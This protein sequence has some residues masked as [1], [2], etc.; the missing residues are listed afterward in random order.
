MN[1]VIIKSINSDV[2]KRSKGGFMKRFKAQK[3]YLVFMFILTVFMVLPGCGGKGIFGGGEWNKVLQYIEVTPP[4]QSI[5]NG[6]TQQFM[7]TGIYSNDSKSDLTPT[8]TWSSSNTAVATIAANGMVTALT[9]GT[10][11]ITA[12][13]VVAKKSG[14]APLNVTS[15]T[16]SSMVVTPVAQ[17]SAKGTTLQFKATG[18]YSDATTQDLTSSVTW[19][20]TPLVSPVASIS[21]A[22]GTNGVATALTVGGPVTITAT[23]AASGKTDSTT[24][25]V[26]AATLSSLAVTPVNPSIANG[27]T[28]QFTA[29]GINSDNTSIAKTSSV[30]WLSS[31]PAVASINPAGLLIGQATALTVGTTTITATDAATGKTNSTTLTVTAATLSSMVVTPVAQSSAK[32]T[33]LQFKA[34]GV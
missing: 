23:D 32:G 26:T 8:V 31:N 14:S 1:F 6:T 4:N 9:A 33:T 34:T 17:S 22:A 20:T 10:A 3:A 16:L 18:V 30:T 28:L 11:T 15:A 29:T 19:K 7:A 27:T 25:T 13:D 21:N 24:L 2:N 12:T 5:A